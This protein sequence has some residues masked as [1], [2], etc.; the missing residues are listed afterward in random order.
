MDTTSVLPRLELADSGSGRRN[1]GV[2]ALDVLEEAT[3]YVQSLAVHRNDMPDTGRRAKLRRSWQ[4]CDDAARLPEAEFARIEY[5]DAP[6]CHHDHAVAV[7]AVKDDPARQRE[8]V[9][10]DSLGT[11]D[12]LGC[13]A[14]L[15]ILGRRIPHFVAK[16]HRFLPEWA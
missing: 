2:G 3:V 7:H 10:A 4:L 16:C 9:L 12:S 8:Q 5:Q 1:R 14:R 13:L 15:E 6:R 11:E